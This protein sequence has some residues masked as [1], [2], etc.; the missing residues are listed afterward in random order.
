ME[1]TLING[2]RVFVSPNALKTTRRPR[3]VHHKTVSMSDNYHARIQKKW[4]KRFGFESEPCMYQT[5]AGL[6]VHPDLIPQLRA[7]FLSLWL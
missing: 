6:F 7:S 3:R 2:V 4:I 1:S 5:P